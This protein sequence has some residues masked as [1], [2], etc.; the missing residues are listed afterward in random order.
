[1]GLSSFPLHDNF[2][3]SQP[4]ARGKGDTPKQPHPFLPFLSKSHF[5]LLQFLLG[6]LAF[7]NRNRLLYKSFPA[8]P[9]S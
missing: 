9:V 2:N 8:N 6:G 5:S 3:L 1:M 7:C 4:S